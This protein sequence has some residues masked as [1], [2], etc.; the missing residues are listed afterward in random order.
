MMEHLEML[1]YLQQ[2]FPTESAMTIVEQV[3][4]GRDFP[5]QAIIIMSRDV[6]FHGKLVKKGVVDAVLDHLKHPNRTFEEE[7][8]PSGDLAFPTV[9]INV[10]LNLSCPPNLPQEMVQAV[11]MKV[12]GNIGPL[13]CVMVDCNQREFFCSKEDWLS[14]TFFFVALIANLVLSPPAKNIVEQ[15]KGLRQFLVR[16][17]YLDL[18]GGNRKDEMIE[19]E[20]KKRCLP[21]C[22]GKMQNSAACAL[23]EFADVSRD[24]NGLTLEGITELK[25]L[26]NIPVAP[27]VDVTFATGLLDLIGKLRDD[28]EASCLCLDS[29]WSTLG[30]IV[31][32]C[33]LYLQ[34]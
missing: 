15:H 27:D 11:Q 8:A 22:I 29:F 5:T 16:M 26:S 13:N 2:T 28:T 30:Q 19:A 12:A 33:L 10:L 9:W 20:A 1:R 14:G 18:Y 6:Q 3:R 17:L 21:G 4:E 25:V 34:N 24:I 32:A 31:F 7:L 23:Q